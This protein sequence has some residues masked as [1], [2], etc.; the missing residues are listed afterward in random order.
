MNPLSR[1]LLGR[2]GRLI[3]AGIAALGLV[4]FAG[5][6]KSDP[7]RTWLNFLL[8]SF[9][10]L[11]LSVASAAFIAIHTAARA[12]WPQALRPIPEAMTAYLPLGALLMLCLSFGLPTLYEWSHAETVASDPILQAKSPFLDPSAFQIRMTLYLALW[13]GLTLLLVRRPRP[14]EQGHGG[15]RAGPGVG[16]SALFLVLFALS[17]S[18]ASVDW[19]MSLEPHWYS[20]LFPWYVFTGT[21]VNVTAVATLL[22]ILLRRKGLFQDV[23][24]DHFH[25]LG[26]YLFGFSF[27]WG[28]LWFCQFLLIWY[29]NIPEEAVYYVRRMEQGWF[30]PF[31]INPL[32]LFAV[33]FCCLLPARFKKTQHV[34]LPV[35]LLLI[36]GHWLDLYLMV[37]PSFF[38]TGP[39]AGLIEAGLFLGFASLYLLRFD[40]AL[41]RASSPAANAPFPIPD[42]ARAAAPAAFRT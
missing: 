15:R 3:L 32:I 18:L 31:L 20:T 1:S 4:T 34:L 23:R 35:C 29:S 19:L 24:E 41:S 7:Q 26:K 2:R 14:G 25:D 30:A 33:P 11:S 39:R 8:C 21:L 5:G 37:M 10:F 9:Y 12:T 17:F 42:A 6:L 28:Y 13:I 16:T 36:I 40:H 27:F 38:P 22:L